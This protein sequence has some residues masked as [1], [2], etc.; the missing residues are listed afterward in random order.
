[1]LRMSS[2]RGDPGTSD[3][4]RA[5]RR[6]VAVQGAALTSPHHTA[7]MVG[8][9]SL[10]NRNL[11][12]MREHLERQTR[13]TQRLQEEVEQA[14]RLTMD[15]ISRSLEDSSPRPPGSLSVTLDGLLGVTYEDVLRSSGQCV[16][17]SADPGTEMSLSVRNGLE[18]ETLRR[19]CSFT[20]KELLERAVEEYAQQVQELQKKLSE[21][22]ELHEQHKFHFRQSIIQLQ[23]KLQ[24]SQVE[25]DALADTRQKECQRQAELV[26][27]LQGTVREL[28]AARHTQEQKTREAINRMELLSEKREAQE[29]SLREVHSIL[30]VYEERTGK[31]VYENE[32]TASLHNQN[33]A[34]AVGKVL[35]DLEA[36]NSTLRLRVLPV[37]EQLGAVKREAQGQADLMR[38]QHQQREQATSQNSLCLRQVTELESTVSHLRS[39]LREAKRMYEDKMESLEKTLILTRTE[40]EE[41]QCERDQYRQQSGD[42]ESQLCQLKSDLH[43]TREEQSLEKEQNKRL[44][45]RDAGNSVAIDNLRRELDEKSVEIQRLEATVT[46]LREECRVQVDR[47]LADEQSKNKSLEEVACLRQELE[48]TKDLLLRAREELKNDRALLEERIRDVEEAELERKKMQVLL[49]ERGQE[50]MQRQEEA[51][52]SRAQLEEALD[53]LKSLQ[54]EGEAVRLRL[55]EKEKIV[56]MMR[57]QMENVTHIAGQQSQH[58]ETLH[59]EKVELLNNVNEHKLEIQQIKADCEVKDCRLSEL[60]QERVQLLSALSDKACCV[61]ELMMEKQQLTA[62]LELQRRQLVSLTEEHKRIRLR[63][64]ESK[65]EETDNLAAKLKAQ[66]ATTRSELEQTKSKLWAL[67]GSDGHGIKVAM[68]MQRQITAKRGQIDVLQSRI[69]FLEEKVENMAQEKR[70]Q[71]SESSRLSQELALVTSEKNRLGTEVET[72]RS[73]ER[74]LKDKVAKLEAALDKLSE[75]FAECQDMIQQQEQD[76]MRLK[77][78][79]ALDVKELQGPIFRVPGNQQ[80]PYSYSTTLPT[81][82][83]TS[84]YLSAPKS[85][86][87]Q[88]NPTQELKSLVR[89]LKSVIECDSSSSNRS[90]R[91]RSEPEGPYTPALNEVTKDTNGTTTLTKDSFSSRL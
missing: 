55:S 16:P 42:L 85:R 44:W 23:T 77:L 13:E 65:S 83:Q 47:Q 64:Q 69:H 79:H 91:R 78:Q 37:E 75:R 60:E 10:G 81:S 8:F 49:E 33:L 1:M 66:L 50:M 46:S 17:D 27:Q 45:H 11:E 22:Y 43:K 88:D 70:N 53:C 12:E 41:A 84:G 52:H 38:Q 61:K 26:N 56:N 57:Q 86:A 18:L 31:K 35:R 4:V 89:E 73:L 32:I 67:E 54:G 82:Q 87:L 6:G 51:Q 30:L 80:K 14:T 34:T 48:A 76:F 62:E 9:P 74:Q 68:G 20:G 24:E 5:A 90:Q 59:G 63:R 15:K 40:A 21:T 2:G 39:E 3:S 71:A 28:E 25:K 29:T 36:E 58:C 19:S 72:L 7:L